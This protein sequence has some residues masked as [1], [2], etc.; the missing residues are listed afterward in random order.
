ME[1]VQKLWKRCL[2][3][4]RG[5]VQIINT[6]GDLNRRIYLHGSTRKHEFIELKESIKPCKIII[7]PESKVKNTW[8]LIMMVLMLYTGIYIP[9]KT[10]FIDSSTQGVFN[11]ELSIDCLFMFD[12]FVNFLSAYEDKD[13]NIEFRLHYIAFAYIRSWF[14]FDV[15]ACIPFQF[16]DK[17]S[18]ITTG[19]TNTG[20]GNY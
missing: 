7:M 11:F 9:Y 15:I 17:S 8:N 10:A 18:E 5:A 1:K 6:F 12:V 14:L 2:A 16:L 19:S 4:T 13:K 20:G 3:K